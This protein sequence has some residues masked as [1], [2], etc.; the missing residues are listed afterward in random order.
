MK[1]VT[2]PIDFIDGAGIVIDGD[3]PIIME[4]DI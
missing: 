4:L 2:P 1:P 3:D